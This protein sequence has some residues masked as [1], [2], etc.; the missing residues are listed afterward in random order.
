M[1]RNRF[2]WIEPFIRETREVWYKSKL[3]IRE[4]PP[5]EKRAMTSYEIGR[6][7]EQDVA[8]RLGQLG[9][10]V[11][12]PPGSTTP[13]DVWGSRYYENSFHLMLVQVKTT[14]QRP[15]AE[16]LSDLDEENLRNFTGLTYRRLGLS[17]FVPEEVRQ[18][19]RFVSA[20][21]AGIR[22]SAGFLQEDRL[23]TIEN[24]YRLSHSPYLI[25]RSDADLLDALHAFN[26]ADRP[27]IWRS[28]AA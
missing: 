23:T 13:A 7:G 24:A 15:H 28:E 6:Y 11:A 8:R 19:Q 10:E 4:N 27:Y 18:G 1:L 5:R 25:L 20:G 16:R 26:G 14:Y 17:V 2:W 12:F 22:V 9:Y 3:R 21:Y